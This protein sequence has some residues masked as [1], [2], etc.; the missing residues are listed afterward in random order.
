MKY[1]EYAL[2]LGFT[3]HKNVY[4]L[5]M[6]GFKVYLRDWQYMILTIQSFYI[7]LDRP[8]NKDMIKEIQFAALNNACAM[9]SLGNKNDTLI[10][11][12]PEGN[13]AKEKTQETM[14]E[15]LKGAITCLKD[16]GYLPMSICPI[17]KKE[18]EYD[19]FGSHFCPIHE[20]CR[21]SYIQKLEDLVKEDK[22]FNIKYVFAILFAVI[23][24]AIGLITPILLTI[25]LHDYFT[26]VL[27]LIPILATLGLFLSHAPSKKWVKLTVGGFVFI[28]VITFLCISIP[29]MASFKEDSL[30]SYM[31][32]NGW[33]G[34]RKAIFGFILSFGGFG[35]AKFLD[36]F[37][38]DYKKEL[39]SFKEIEE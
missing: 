14:K 22:S 34:F 18:A 16:N 5:E 20:D 17:C 29:Y 10:I 1:D 24:I 8:L 4:V 3:K 32:T 2:S 35:G 7:P 11:T 23:G 26:G 38:K 6:D 27:A 31:F 36:K 33:V 21:N 19:V 37:K 15:M 13:K 25:F 12:L 30:Y 9:A 28:S 39:E